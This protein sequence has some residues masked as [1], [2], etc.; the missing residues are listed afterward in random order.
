M[1]ENTKDNI[2][3]DFQIHYIWT[4]SEPT[5]CSNERSQQRTTVVIKNIEVA[6][7][8]DDDIQ[9]K[10][11]EKLQQYQRLNKEIWTVKIK[12]VPLVREGYNL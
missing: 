2:Q 3:W 11:Y 5:R 6:I 10:V 4:N 9:W 7:S 12:T 1:I 8:N